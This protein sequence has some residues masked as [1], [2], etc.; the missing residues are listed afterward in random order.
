MGTPE[1]G[2]TLL[3][4]SGTASVVS[5]ALGTPL[6]SVQ[7]PGDAARAIV[8]TASPQIP[9]SLDGVVTGVVGLDGLVQEHSMIKQAHPGS[10]GSPGAARG[11]GVASGAGA[12]TQSPEAQAPASGS[13]GQTPAAIAHV[14]TPQA[15]PGRPGRGL[16]GHLHLDPAFFD[17]RPRPGAGAGPHRHRAVHRHRGVRAVR[18]QRLR[19]LPGL[20]RVV[21]LHPQRVDRR[22][23]GRPAPG[24][25]RR[26]RARYRA[27][28]RQRPLRR[29]CRLR[30][31]Q[32]QRRPGLRPVQPDRQR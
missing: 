22:G 28:R 3:P 15:C 1:P 10:P 19:R 7:A 27:G 31:T 23:A 11:L 16:R 18:R 26:G 30:G 9:A 5:A 20:L 29:P 14:G 25:G 6:E 32:R 21:E 4:V 12:T 24:E 17:L 13:P 8:N 2:S